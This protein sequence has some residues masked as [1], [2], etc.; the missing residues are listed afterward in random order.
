MCLQQLVR[1]IPYF[2]PYFLVLYYYNNIKKENNNN[3]I[4]FKIQIF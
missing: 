3:Y 2:L 4:M 1:V